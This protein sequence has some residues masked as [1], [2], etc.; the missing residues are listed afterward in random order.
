MQAGVS[1]CNVNGKAVAVPFA[2]KKILV[3]DPANGQA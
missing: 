2:A 1:V 3:M